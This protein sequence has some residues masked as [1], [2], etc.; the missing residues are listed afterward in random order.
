MRRIRHLLNREDGVGIVTALSVAFIVFSLGA[1][2][3]ALAVHELDEVVADR[4]RTQALHAA[5]AG[6]REATAMLAFDTDGFRKDT[7]T[8][9]RN[10][11]GTTGPPG[12]EVCT[13]RELRS[14]DLSFTEVHGEYWVTVEALGDLRYQIDAWGWAPT[15]TARQSGERHIKLDVTLIPLGGFK[16]ALFAA[17]GGI[18]GSN[19]KEIY[20]TVY[21]GND[22][23]LGNFTRVYRNDLPYAGDGSVRVYGDLLIPNGTNVEIRG[24]VETQGRVIDQNG[25]TFLADVVTRN[26][27]NLGVMPLPQ[28]SF[29]KAYIDGE[30]KSAAAR[31]PAS[32]FTNVGLINDNVTDLE[33]LPQITLPKF[34][35]NEPAYVAAGFTV[36]HHANAAAMQIYI[37]ANQNDLKGIHVIDNGGGV[38]SFH[39]ATY[40]DHFMLV[41]RKGAAPAGNIQ[42]RGTPKAGSVPAGGPATVVI[43]TVDT[44][45][46]L[47]LGQSFQSIPEEVHHLIFSNGDFASVNQTTVYGAVY[48]ERDL[49]NN[50]LEIHFRPPDDNF[51]EGAF[52]FDPALADRFIAEPGLWDNDSGAGS[53]VTAFCALP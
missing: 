37:D 17:S 41:V 20:G 15:H 32:T 24:D 47:E 50:R 14:T 42:V 48:G 8:L 3:Y 35:F 29:K 53:P 52:E 16:D 51:I 27:Q 5:E 4:H 7:D 9:G 46:L 40:T 33:D 18:V 26:W 44:G 21:S 19:R 49:S 36:T 45:G 39:Q 38:V 31:N 22:L 43:I 25:S 30:L 12:S 6:I 13:L 23:T 1:T 11:F 34:T 28:N 10:D 2:W